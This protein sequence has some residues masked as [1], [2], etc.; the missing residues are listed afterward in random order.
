MSENLYSWKVDRV[1]DDEDMDL[2]F[3]GKEPANT[4]T[5]QAVQAP[6][7]NPTPDTPAEPVKPRITRPRIIYPPASRKSS[8]LAEQNTETPKELPTEPTPVIDET[9]N[10]LEDSDRRLTR[11]RTKPARRGLH[12]KRERLTTDTSEEF[13]PALR[14]TCHLLFS[15]QSDNFGPHPLTFRPLLIPITNYVFFDCC[16]ILNTFYSQTMGT[17]SAKPTALPLIES[18]KNRDFGLLEEAHFSITD[19]LFT[20]FH[21]VEFERSMAKTTILSD[22]GTMW[23]ISM[24]DPTL[25]NAF[26]VAR[27]VGLVVACCLQNHTSTPCASPAHTTSARPPCPSSLHLNDVATP[28]P[29]F[30]EQLLYGES[31]SYVPPSSSSAQPL[32][33]HLLDQDRPAS[34]QA[35]HIPP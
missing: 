33:Q 4:V 12:E 13:A 2:G 30:V 18:P 9:I 35:S 10:I 16:Y 17:T 29:P 26:Y 3:L 32:A 15:C 19:K 25:T 22:L 23:H 27:R 7:S 8:R 24:T 6:T 21:S 11:I 20:N 1:D 31:C 28:L 34:S 5:T 14:M